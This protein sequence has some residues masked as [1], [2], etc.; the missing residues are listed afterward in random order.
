LTQ[1]LETPA[2]AAADDEVTP[3]RSRRRVPTLALLVAGCFALAALS[4][5]LPS[6][7]T[8]DSWSWVVWGREVAHLDLDTSA[9]SSW[10]PFVYL[11]AM[12]SGR[13]PDTPVVDEPVTINGWT[14]H[15]YTNTYIGPTNLQN[16]LAQSL[17]TV[18]ARLAD[19]VGRSNVAA[20]A[21]RLGITTPINT[22][23]AMALGT[24]QV[25]PLEMAQ[26]YAA[27]ANGG[28]KTEAYGIER[29]RTTS[30]RVLYEHPHT[31]RASVIGQPALS[32]MIRMMRAVMTTGSGTHANIPGF[33]LAGKTGTT[34]D[35]RDAW[36][37]GYTGG[38]VTAVWVGKDDN[39]PMR[40]V[41]GAGAP[42]EIW[43][44][45]MTA[46]LPRLKVQPIP[47]ASAPAPPPSGD[48][49]GDLLNST[50]NSTGDGGDQGDGQQP[51]GPSDDDDRGPPG[52]QPGDRLPPPLPPQGRDSGT[53]YDAAA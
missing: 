53:P 49:I 10:K 14:P 33:D 4:L 13:T 45:F 42:S 38:F 48:P 16:A 30:G 43:R 47:G 9:G 39:T 23:P 18:A 27:F 44:G 3:R 1:T 19:E 24:S 2:A 8:Q 32:Y 6:V 50:G 25:S 52:P 46:A 22:D 7:P 5:L 35:Y 12:E 36:F 34:S 17:N 40:K 20:T 26:A 15:N 28:F 21:H 11:T 41:T 51:S 31:A 37:I 29:I